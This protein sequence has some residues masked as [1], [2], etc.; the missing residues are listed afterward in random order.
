MR[1]LGAVYRMFDAHHDARIHAVA[2]YNLPASHRQSNQIMIEGGEA[3]YQENWK[4]WEQI[5]LRLSANLSSL[6]PSSSS[7]PHY[8]DF[9]PSINFINCKFSDEDDSGGL[10]R[11]GKKGLYRSVRG[12][13]LIT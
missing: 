4:Q 12:G 10:D 7:K 2:G 11:S 6:L 5:L 8:W 3:R 13:K 1:K 9:H